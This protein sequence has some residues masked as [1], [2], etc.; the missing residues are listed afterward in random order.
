M[1]NVYPEPK[2]ELSCWR[3]GTTGHRVND[4][5]VTHNR[6]QE[7]PVYLLPRS[8]GRGRQ[9]AGAVELKVGEVVEVV[10]VVEV[11]E[12][13]STH[14]KVLHRTNNIKWSR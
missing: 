8:L 4:C 2:K 1:T 6:L 5:K 9:P 11:G 7:H 12:E 3:C 10:E 14:T 13:V